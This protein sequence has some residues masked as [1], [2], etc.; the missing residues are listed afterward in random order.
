MGTRGGNGD[1]HGVVMGT[2][3]GMGA[4]HNWDRV[5]MGTAMGW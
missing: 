1:S 2:G 5:A 4:N 3:V